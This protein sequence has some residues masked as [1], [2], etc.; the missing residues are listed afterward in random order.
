MVSEV[1]LTIPGVVE[2]VPY[3]CSWVV[4]VAEKVGLS[5]RDVNHCELAVDEACTN[6]IEHGYGLNG[7]DKRIDIVCRDDKDRFTITIIDEAPQYNP[8]L[9]PEPD[10]LMALEER[11]DEGGGWGVYFIKR[12]MD[13]VDYRYASQRNHLIMSKRITQDE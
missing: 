4:E 9:T 8:L 13:T 1:R 7:A 3:A 5:M 11:P 12:L 10:P 2:R 6:I